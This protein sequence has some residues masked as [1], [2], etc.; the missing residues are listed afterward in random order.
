MTIPARRRV[1]GPGAGWRGGSRC[2]RFHHCVGGGGDRLWVWDCERKTGPGRPPS[3]R[4]IAPPHGHSPVTPDS[5]VCLSSLCLGPDCWTRKHQTPQPGPWAPWER[6]GCPSPRHSNA[7][8]VLAS[9]IGLWPVAP[10]R[11]HCLPRGGLDQGSR[12]VHVLI[13]GT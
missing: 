12:D 7:R 8:G 9:L 3:F 6:V 4:A 2:V 10:L 1:S 13:C 11:P 5:S